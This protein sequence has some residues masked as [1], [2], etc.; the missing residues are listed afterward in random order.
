M[1]TACDTGRAEDQCR[2]ATHHGLHVPSWLA[3]QM[4]RLYDRHLGKG[5]HEHSAERGSGRASRTSMM[6]ELWK[7]TC[8]LK[9]RL[10]QFVRRR[11]VEQAERRGESGET[12]RG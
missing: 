6:A 11:A 12:L 8:G 7:S 3:S 10:L 5:W 2:S 1:D 4:F 9:P